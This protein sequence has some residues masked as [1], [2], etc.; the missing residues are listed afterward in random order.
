MEDKQ[1][2]TVGDFEF[3]VFETPGHTVGSVCY[4]VNEILFTGDLL[5]YRGFGNTCFHGGSR[6]DILTSIKMLFSSFPLETPVYSGHGPATTIG[7]EKTY[8][9]R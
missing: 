1:I 6:R 9:G 7:S 4:Y 2:L 8:Y 3:K 5:F